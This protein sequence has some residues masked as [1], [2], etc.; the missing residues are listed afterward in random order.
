MES[1]SNA[2]EKYDINLV[3]PDNPNCLSALPTILFEIMTGFNKN[4]DVI[5]SY[6]FGRMGTFISHLAWMDKKTQL[7]DLNVQEVAQ[8]FWTLFIN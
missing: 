3:S 8:I 6:I 7:D 4:F 1:K 5:E 2:F